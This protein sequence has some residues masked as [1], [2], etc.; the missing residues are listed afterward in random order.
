MKVIASMGV[1][2]TAPVISLW[3]SF[4][5]CSGTLSVC[6]GAV[7]RDSQ[8]YVITGRMYFWYVKFKVDRAHPHLLPARRWCVLVDSWN[9]LGLSPSADTVACCWI[10]RATPSVRRRES[11]W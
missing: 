11:I 10:R 6:G 8:L 2:F 1:V 5:A 7:T 3:A 4:W 9:F